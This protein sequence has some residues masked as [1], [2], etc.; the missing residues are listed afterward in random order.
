M[1]T[2]WFFKNAFKFYVPYN[3]NFLLISLV[4]QNEDC[5]TIQELNFECD[6]HN[7]K[8]CTVYPCVSECLAVSKDLLSLC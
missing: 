1:F 3:I 4:K 7:A 6:F 8:T 5:G 2:D